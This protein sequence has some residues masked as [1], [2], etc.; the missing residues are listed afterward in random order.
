V[1][2]TDADGRSATLIILGILAI[3][4]GIYTIFKNGEKMIEGRTQSIQAAGQLDINGIKKGEQQMNDGIKNL[5]NNVY[6]NVVS[7]YIAGPVSKFASLKN[8]PRFLTKL[9][10]AYNAINDV[11][12]LGSMNG[13]YHRA[14]FDA[15]YSSDGN[16][17]PSRVDYEENAK[18]TEEF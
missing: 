15:N 14:E 2:L 4:A 16:S 13:T 7:S 5:E 8:A 11:S 10:D 6:D 9:S 1:N 12:S 17:P 18:Y 3:S